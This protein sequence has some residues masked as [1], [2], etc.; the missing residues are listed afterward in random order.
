MSI[1]I[2]IETICRICLEE[3][4][5]N[6]LIYP[7][8]CS[9]NIKYVHK[10]CL[11]KWFYTSERKECEICKYEFKKKGTIIQ[12]S[13]IHLF[14]TK[15]IR[16]N[17]FNISSFL[18][19]LIISYSYL[20]FLIDT[21]LSLPH[22]VNIYGWFL[23]DTRI[24]YYILYSILFGIVCIYN[25]LIEIIQLDNIYVKRY[26]LLTFN[27]T[28]LAIFI[29]IVLYY[30]LGWAYTNILTDYTISIIN[31]LIITKNHITSINTINDEL[32]EIENYPDN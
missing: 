21:N 8:K 26:I 19:A 1:K 11:N 9:G 13:F 18:F 15:K 32:E 14:L 16:N 5:L 2:H 20:L 17:Y 7:C 31:Y 28:Y 27:N 6:N 24:Y 3:D 30:S 25:M 23:H 22:K 29:A 4:I 10:E 12:Y